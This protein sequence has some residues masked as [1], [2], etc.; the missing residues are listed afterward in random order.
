MSTLRWFVIV[1]V[2][3]AAFGTAQGQML[4]PAE[5]ALCGGTLRRVLLGSAAARSIEER[6]GVIDLRRTG[7]SE[8]CCTCHRHTNDC[9]TAVGVELLR[10]GG[11]RGGGKGVGISIA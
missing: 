4:A 1:V 10:P 6:P 2:G 8:N 7:G 3:A 5:A 11:L 9:R